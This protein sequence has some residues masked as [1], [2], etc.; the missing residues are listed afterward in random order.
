MGSLLSPILAE[1]YMNHLENR[2]LEGSKFCGM[3]RH[4]TR[5]VDDILIVWAG[6]N[7]QMDHFLTETN[8][9]NENIKFTVEKGNNTINYL[10]LT[11]TL[12]RNKVEYQIYQKPTHTDAVIPKDSFHRPKHK[13]AALQN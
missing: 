3:I 7:R 12:A 5:Y 10:D 4:W 8:A 13:I 1:I 11:I 9:M 2:I 6:T